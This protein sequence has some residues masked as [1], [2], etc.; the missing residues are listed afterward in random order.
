MCLTDMSGGGRVLSYMKKLCLV[1]FTLLLI[2][3]KRFEIIS[4]PYWDAILSKSA[5]AFYSDKNILRKGYRIKYITIPVQSTAL[6]IERILE[7]SSADIILLSPLFSR[8]EENSRKDLFSGR[9]YYFSFSKNRSNIKTVKDKNIAVYGYD[10]IPFKVI[11]AEM[12]KL[13]DLIVKERLN[14]DFPD[15]NLDE[16]R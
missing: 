6:D 2:S 15:I 14:N 9:I 16:F 4:D 10:K 3:C 12:M 13:L 11:Q 8:F 1:F 5:G 7:K